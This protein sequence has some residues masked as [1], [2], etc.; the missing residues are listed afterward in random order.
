MNFKIIVCVKQV[1]DTSDIKWTANNTIQREGLDSII[2]PYDIGAIQLAKN[3]KSLLKK[4]NINTTI[5]VVT[6][7]PNQAIDVLRTAISFGCDNAFLL[8]DKKFS[9][10]DTLATAYTLSQFIKCKSNDFSLIICGQQAIDG[11]TAQTPSALAEKLNIPQVTNSI[12]L[13]DINE[14]YSIW[15]RETSELRE[16]VK[17]GYPALITT[18][19]KFISI[20]PKINDYIRAQNATISIL[21]S[22][23]ICADINK[24]GL[25][26]SPTQV[27]KAFKPTIPRNTTLINE[28]SSKECANYIINEIN[29]CRGNNG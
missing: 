1:P 27:R 19:N 22:T 8:S 24:I 7:G 18:I 6:M 5:D 23:S 28:C 13:K 21:D 16:D 20:K 11:D 17:I 15:T 12:A 3:V 14:T 29:Q 9:G 10:A 4:R 25:I 2:N 26:G